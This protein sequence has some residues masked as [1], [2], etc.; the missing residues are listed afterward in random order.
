VTRVLPLTFYNLDNNRPNDQMAREVRA[1]LTGPRPAVLGVCE[2]VG[3]N[4]PGVEGW[5]VYR[6]TSTKSRA[7]IAAYVK[8]NLEVTGVQ[9]H[10]LAETWSRT[11]HPGTHE[12][13]SILE[14]RAGPLQ[15]LVHHQ[16]PKGT[17]NTHD[18]QQEGIDKLEARMAPWTRDDW[19]T[20]PQAD[21]DDARAQPRVVLW[22]AN[23]KPG[24]EGPGPTMLAGRIDGVTVGHR[25]DGAVIRSGRATSIAYPERVDG[26]E[27]CSD[28][29]CA[30]TFKIEVE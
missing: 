28:H 8:N 9:W 14:L 27:L 21:K 25:I 6:D 1:L 20:R 16:P 15:V 23:R 12:P 29:E 7:N 2:A 26:C 10:D 5:R 3:Y 4:L 30:F 19:S 11:E 17:D 22:D 13:R 24:E 18:A